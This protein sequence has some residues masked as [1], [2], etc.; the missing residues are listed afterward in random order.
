MD[1]VT[2]SRPERWGSNAAE[3]ARVLQAAIAAGRVLDAL[4]LE[5][6][7][8][9]ALTA[10]L[11]EIEASVPAVD[12]GVPTPRTPDMTPAEARALAWRVAEQEVER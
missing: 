12:P 9:A 6:L 1:P 2:L 7:E 4:E 5:V 10:R 11:A 3:N 8:D